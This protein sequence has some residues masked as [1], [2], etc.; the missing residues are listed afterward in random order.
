MDQNIKDQI[1]SMLRE[2]SNYPEITNLNEFSDIARDKF[3]DIV[4]NDYDMYRDFFEEEFGKVHV[5][6]EDGSSI[7]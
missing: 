6:P 4:G 5:F 1:V 7:E 2:V 3:S